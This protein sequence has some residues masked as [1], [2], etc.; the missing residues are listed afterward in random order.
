MNKIKSRRKRD[1]GATRVAILE[2]AR[3]LLAKDGPEGLSVSQVA[4]QAGVNRGTAYQHFQTREQLLHA[5][6]VWVS[7]TLCREVFGDSPHAGDETL[8]DVD[9]QFVSEHLANFAME[10]PELGR[11]WLFEVLGSDQPSNDPFW[12]LYNTR[13]ERFARTEFAQPGIDCE[14]HSVVT[15]IGAFLWP[16]WARAHT[17][18][19]KERQQMAKRYS[20]EMLRLS[21]HGTMRP[22]KYRELDARLSEVLA[23]KPGGRKRGK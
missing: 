16:V 5:T 11:V 15:L 12:K 17:R 2:A 22:E 18:T 13:F 3:T 21:L 20:N 7:E 14:V 1:P 9:P 10:N 6:A 8:A 4:Q 19:V 23:K